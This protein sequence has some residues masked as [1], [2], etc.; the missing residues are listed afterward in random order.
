MCNSHRF[1]SGFWKNFGNAKRQKRKSE[2]KVKVPNFGQANQPLFPSG[3]SPSFASSHGR[4]RGHGRRAR[5]FR[6]GSLSKAFHTPRIRN[7]VLSILRGEGSS[8]RA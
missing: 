8:D 1:V 4:A 6:F 2:N 3:S 7:R 5:A